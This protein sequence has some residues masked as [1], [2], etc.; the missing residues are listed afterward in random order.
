[1]KIVFQGGAHFSCALKAAGD[2]I[3]AA[4]K[5]SHPQYPF[6]TAV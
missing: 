3:Y 5:C 2:D 6:S 4:A 1:M